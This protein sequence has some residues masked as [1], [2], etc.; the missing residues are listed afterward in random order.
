MLHVLLGHER[1][2]YGY[3][4]QWRWGHGGERAR[5]HVV[6]FFG[7][8]RNVVGMERDGRWAG[9]ENIV[10]MAFEA[11]DESCVARCVR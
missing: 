1:I 7:V 2:G 10:E 5:H 8:E 9:C 11:R 6:C 3:Q 4:A